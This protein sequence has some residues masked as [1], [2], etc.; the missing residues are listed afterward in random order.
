MQANHSEIKDLMSTIKLTIEPADYQAEVEKEIVNVRKK[1]Q[2]PGFRPGMVPKSLVKKMYGKGI[3]ADVI[4]KL[5]GE[6]LGEYC[7]ANNLRILGEPLPNEAETSEVDFDNMDT[8]TFAFDIAIAPEFSAKLDGKNK[9]TEYQIE[10]TDEMVQKQ[11]DSY[12]ERFGEYVEAEA[13]TEGAML[14]GQLIEE[15]E[16]GGIV[17]EGAV[18]SPAYMKSKTEQKKFAKAKKGDAIVFNPKKAYD[19]EVEISSMLG[20]SKEE[21]EALTSDFRF[22]I[23]SITSH[24]AAAIDGEL[25]AKV[26]GENNIKDE[27]DF[28]ARVKAEIEANMAE[29]SKYKFGL[30]TKA[31]IMKKMEKVQFP[32]EFLKKWVKATNAELTDEQ[33]EKDFPGMIEE[34]KWHLAK[35]QLM[36]EYNIDVKKEEVEAYAKEVAKMQFMQYGLMHIEEQYLNNFAQEMLKKEDQLRGIVERVAEN[37]LYEALKGVAK[38]EKKAISH[39][40]F[41]KLF[42]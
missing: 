8:F 33:L 26:Y 36:K 38:V 40:E 25:F 42:A 18:L 11:I 10:V 24:K 39:E 16:E 20:I 31:A 3:L 37:K 9:L 15:K 4:N 35:D 30:D 17:K 14:R 7:E 2:F 41:G 13:Y 23:E 32:E 19:S 5:I 29:D 1:A 21:A 28:R 6:K 12:A 27:A 34:L 22:E